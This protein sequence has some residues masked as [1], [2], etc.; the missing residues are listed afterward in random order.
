MGHVWGWDRSFKFL[1]NVS[2][3]R[4]WSSWENVYENLDLSKRADR[5]LGQTE[6]V[7]PLLPRPPTANLKISIK[8]DG[9]KICTKKILSQFQDEIR[10]EKCFGWAIFQIRLFKNLPK[11]TSWLAN[12]PKRNPWRWWWRWFNESK[13]LL[14]TTY[15]NQEL[16]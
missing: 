10:K 3:L 4:G 13:F 15:N 12:F 16:V 14:Y 11:S 2:V 9:R 5:F 7:G 8:S 1:Q 6:A